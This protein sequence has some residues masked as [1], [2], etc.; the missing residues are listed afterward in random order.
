MSDESDL[1]RAESQL[2]AAEIIDGERSQIGH[3][4]HDLLLPLIF[5]ASANVESVLSN[6]GSQS[7]S[8]QQLSRL[9]QSGEWLKQA[10]AVG[11]GLLNQIYPPE[12]EGVGWLAAAKETVRR[13][14]N[15]ADQNGN[16]SGCEVQWTVTEQSPVGDP[17]WER[18]VA[19]AAYRVLVEAVRNATRHG[20]AESLSIR[21]N[22]LEILIV[23]DGCGFDP[24]SV[25]PSRFG[26]RSM[27]G[28]AALVGKSVT[29]DSEQGGP[30]TV[31]FAL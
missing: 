22:E 7:L 16:P 19:T 2:T 29:I 23:D 17:A 31:R 1:T 18:D 5:A 14:T 6:N 11:R 4:I 26:L 8:E 9:S 21:C 25:E 13:I 28:R 20:K 24:A 12:L 15:E 27:K 30:T 3:D 10:M